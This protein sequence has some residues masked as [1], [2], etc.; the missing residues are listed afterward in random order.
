M[1]INKMKI[2]EKF[3]RSKDYI[4]LIN[5]ILESSEDD[6]IRNFEHQVIAERSFEVLTQIMLDICTHII[7]MSQTTSPT[8]Y[9]DCMTKLGKIN[10]LNEER[11][12]KYSTLIKM[13]NVIVHQYDTIN[14]S[15]LYES[16]SDLLIDFDNFKK[17]ILEWLEKN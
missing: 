1:S 9:S 16:L 5:K 2:K 11:S 7:A 4:S 10:I 8:S 14:L 15:M 13:R 17:E 3:S 12:L 6:F